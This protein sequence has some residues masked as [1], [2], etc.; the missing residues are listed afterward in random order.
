M[1]LAVG[2]HEALGRSSDLRHEAVIAS[3]SGLH[4]GAVLAEQLLCPGGEGTG[5]PVRAVVREG[6]AKLVP[7]WNGEVVGQ[8]HVPDGCRGAMDRDQSIKH[9]EPIDPR[10]ECAPVV[11][12]AMNVAID[13]SEITI[14][15]AMENI[16]AQGELGSDDELQTV[17]SERSSGP[18]RGGQACS[19]VV[20]LVSGD[21]LP[22]VEIVD[23]HEPLLPLC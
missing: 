7:T 22:C 9:F 3:K 2:D 10:C 6:H 4:V 17:G 19:Y 15:D 16:A 21:P 8:R 20:S 18:E 1:G 11:G 14:V 23:S 5:T 12:G 13:G